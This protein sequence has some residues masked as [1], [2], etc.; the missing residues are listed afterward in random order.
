MTQ[1][2]SLLTACLVTI[3][4]ISGLLLFI[5]R[6]RLSRFASLSLAVVVLFFASHAPALANT[7][8]AA[9]GASDE[10]VGADEDALKTNPGG[11]HYSGLEYVPSTGENQKPV[12][13]STIRKSIESEADDTIVVAVA[14]GS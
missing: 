11:G 8:M 4:G 9:L 7:Q 2:S 6:N 10:A 3:L 12:S 14:N 1:L 13:D 5:Q